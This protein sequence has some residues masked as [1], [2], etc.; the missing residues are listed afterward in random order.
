MTVIVIM[1]TSSGQNLSLL[2]EG[3][4]GEEKWR[5]IKTPGVGRGPSKRKRASAALTLWRD[6]GAPG[7]EMEGP[8][9]PAPPAPA[10]LGLQT[11]RL[12]A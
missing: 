8:P 2:L 5:G 10:S 4:S 3:G 6:S 1:C 11:E 9:S 7:A 12:S